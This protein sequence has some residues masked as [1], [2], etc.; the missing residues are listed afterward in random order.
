MAAPFGYGVYRLLTT[1][2][3]VQGI[4][5]VGTLFV[6]KE[7]FG[8]WKTRQATQRE[9]KR[10]LWRSREVQQE[11]EEELDVKSIE[12]DR[13]RESAPRGVRSVGELPNATRKRLIRDR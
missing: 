8:W 9:R 7:L 12:T 1:N 4:A 2:P 5:L 6:S 10:N 11:V 13:A 3:I